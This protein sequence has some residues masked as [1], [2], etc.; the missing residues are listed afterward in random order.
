MCRPGSS[1]VQQRPCSI[2]RRGPAGARHGS[3]SMNLRQRFG[4]AA[5]AGGR[6]R[7]P[8]VVDRPHASQRRRAGRLVPGRRRRVL[9]RP[10]KLARG[11]RRSGSIARAATAPSAEMLHAERQRA[12]RHRRR[13]DHD[14]QRHA[15]RARRRGARRGARRRLRQAGHARP[16]RRRATWSRARSAERRLF[17]V[18]HGYSAYPMTRYARHL[19]SSG[20]H[21]R[22]APRAGGVHPVR[23]GHARRGRAAE[24]SPA[25]DPRSRAQR[26]RAGDE[27]DRLPRAAPG[28][29]R[30]PASAWRGWRPTSARWCRGAR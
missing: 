7:R 22:A 16:S 30:Q 25:L 29:L 15:L 4:R 19:V 10:R 17:A 2:T 18:A 24:Q 23:A 20:A 6:R 11:G 8:G 5:A 21:R 14:A 9:E 13:G 12:R 28:V 26:P 3:R 27:R 1:P